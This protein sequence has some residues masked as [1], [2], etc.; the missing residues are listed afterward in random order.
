MSFD[1]YLSPPNTGEL[2]KKFALDALD[3]G[4]VAPLGP[5]VEQFESELASFVGAQYAVALSSGTAGLHLCL[6]AGGIKPQDE[7][8]VPTMTFAATAFA[9]TYVGA[10]PIF[11][12]SE[13]LTWNV[14]PELLDNFLAK[15]ERTSSLP[16]ALIAVDVFGQCANYP[17]IE[18]ICNKYGVLLIEDAAEAL[19]ATCGKRSAGTFGKAGVFSFNGNKI[20]TTS[21]GGMVVTDDEKFARQIRYLATQARQP[22]SWYEHD[23]VGYNYRLSNILAAIGR[24][25]LQRLPEFI[26]S[27]K[28]ARAAYTEYFKA[29]D[30]VHVIQDSAQGE[31]N[32]WLT[33]LYFEEPSQVEQVR[34]FLESNRIEAR[35]VWKPMHLQPVFSANEAIGGQC[36]TQLFEH[37]LC[38]PSS[39]EQTAQRVI[40]SLHKYFMGK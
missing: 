4:W 18:E 35:H 36:A 28:A 39:D 21:G 20:I 29:V 30:G 11:I 3:S 1:I 38:L 25:Q 2:E 24:A 5:H 6:L 12:D 9:V 34:L 32:Y 15:R 40:E 37:G 26:A 23:D 22:V 7:V 16:K 8:I 13:R 19:G 14:D 27:R 10:Q 17:A 33:I 31:S